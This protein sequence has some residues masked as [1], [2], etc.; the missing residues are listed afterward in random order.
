[1][2]SGPVTGSVDPFVVHG[3]SQGNDSVDIVYVKE[4]NSYLASVAKF[5]PGI[6]VEGY[7]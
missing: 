5:V 2:V 3:M 4:P 6:F 7:S 1:M